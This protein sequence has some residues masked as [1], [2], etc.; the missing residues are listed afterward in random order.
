MRDCSE[1]LDNLDRNHKEVYSFINKKANK[2]KDFF[3]GIRDK[4]LNIYYKCASIV[5]VSIVKK[6][7]VFTTHVKY[8]GKD[9]S[10]LTGSEK[11]E[12][13]SLDDL[14][15]NWSNMLAEIN[16][17]QLGQSNTKNTKSSHK[18]IEKVCQ[19]WIVNE[20][21]SRDESDWYYVDLEY[22][23]Q[24]VPTGRFDMIAVSKK[25]VNG[26]HRVA[27]VELKVNYSSYAGMDG[28][29]KKQ[30][31][32][33]FNLILAKKDELYNSGFELLKFGSGIVGHIADYL[34]FLQ[35]NY[36]N[37]LKQEIVNIIK[38]HNK[39]GLLNNPNLCCIRSITSVDDLADK[40]EV[41]IVSYT[42][43]P[44]NGQTNDDDVTIRELKNSMYKYL[45]EKPI[46]VKGIKKTSEYC[47]ENCIN[48]ANI[49]GFNTLR[50]KLFEDKK[51]KKEVIHCV[52]DIKGEKYDFYFTF[53]DAARSAAWNCLP[54][55]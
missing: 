29:R 50:D 43:G 48:G 42:K 38:C 12:R 33:E 49:N 10:G 52:Q 14:R 18:R 1:L 35:K 9:D 24:G 47:L 19:Q 15:A 51:G 28:S 30:H 45:F 4:Y 2:K 11:Y 5:R 20:A 17:I 44:N 7:P 26:K 41:H 54:K 6:K 23:M 16:N 36:Y 32:K 53:V 3:I 13:I 55:I 46:K 21:N 37:T 40:P 34:R 25:K 22:T 31:E 27:L 39:L 8:L